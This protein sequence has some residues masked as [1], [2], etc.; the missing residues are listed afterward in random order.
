MKDSVANKIKGRLTK[1]VDVLKSDQVISGNFTCR[2][3]VVDLQPAAYNAQRVVK[4]RKLLRVSQAIFARFL[5]VKVRTVQAWEQGEI[6]PSGMACR[7]MDEI[8]LNPDYWQK[9]LKQVIKI[10]EPSR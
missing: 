8:Q 9:R 6:T 1:F 10:K 7:F 3:V 2:T 4:T 5:G